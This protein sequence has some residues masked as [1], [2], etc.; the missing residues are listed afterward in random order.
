MR[1]GNWPTELG[2]NYYITPRNNMRSWN[3][4]VGL[5]HGNWND[6]TI[7]YEVPSVPRCRGYQGKLDT[8]NVLEM[9]SILE[10]HEP[11]MYLFN[12]R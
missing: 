9:L 11:S 12:T 2:G 7:T 1:Q 8:P 4:G 6:D 10:R 3:Q 5:N